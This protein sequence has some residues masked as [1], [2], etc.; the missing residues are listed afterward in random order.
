MICQICSCSSLQ[1]LKPVH[2][3]FM[4][5]L[6]CMSFVMEKLTC[7]TKTL[8]SN[9]CI[10]CNFMMH[11][12][13]VSCQFVNTIFPVEAEIYRLL[14]VY[15]WWFKDIGLIMKSKNLIYFLES[16]NC[17]FHSN[18]WWFWSK[19]ISR[20]IWNSSIF[21]ILVYSVSVLMF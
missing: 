17:Y 15:K 3:S 11:M 6:T 7:N 4:Y 20:V 10:G 2:V 18:S 1:I 14:T 12:L 21:N 9:L 19:F 16:Q 13:K 8:L 5:M